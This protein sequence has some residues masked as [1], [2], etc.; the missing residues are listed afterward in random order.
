MKLTEESLTCDF[1]KLF[2]TSDFINHILSV[3][4]TGMQGIGS[5]SSIF[6]SNQNSYNP[7][8]PIKNR[9]ARI[10]WSITTNI[11]YS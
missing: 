1:R 10:A 11:A 4:I 9:R 5:A 2:L 3:G 8:A 6:T 7:I